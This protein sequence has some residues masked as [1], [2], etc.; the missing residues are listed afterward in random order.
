[1]NIQIL[2]LSLLSFFCLC[3]FPG[4]G[5]HPGVIIS[6]GLLKMLAVLLT[7]VFLQLL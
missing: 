6:S 7:P 2:M 3:I 4:G 5:A 1:M